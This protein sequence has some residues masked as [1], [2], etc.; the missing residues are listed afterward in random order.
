MV[1]NPP[2]NEEAVGGSSSIPGSERSPGEGNGNP[3]SIL[4]WEIPL[5]GEPGGL[6]IKGLQSNSRSL[7]I[8]MSIELVMPS[9]HFIFCHTL[10]LLPSIFPTADLSHSSG[11][12]FPS[13]GNLPDP[14][15][16]PGSPA[17]QTDF[18]PTEPLGNSLAEEPSYC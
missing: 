16:E 10:L 18:S 9:N 14:E 7:P 3:L 4:A 1:K 8:L 5:T 11:Y 12:P 13:P 15:I 6:Q 2:A 17:L